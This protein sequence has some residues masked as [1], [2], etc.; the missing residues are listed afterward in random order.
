MFSTPFQWE[1]IYQKELHVKTFLFR[2]SHRGT[3]RCNGQKSYQIKLLWFV[4]KQLQKYSIRDSNLIMDFT[5]VR[6]EDAAELL[7]P[8]KCA[9]WCDS[10]RRDFVIPMI[11]NP[12]CAFTHSHSPAATPIPPVP[13]NCCTSTWEGVSSDIEMCFWGVKQ[14]LSKYQF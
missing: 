10:K 11:S 14:R 12:S 8:N 3:H 4:Q 6:P 1:G 5:L 9:A 2:S 13:I 7:L